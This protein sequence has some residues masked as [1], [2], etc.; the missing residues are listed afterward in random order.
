M[1]NY[2]FTEHYSPETISGIRGN[3]DAIKKSIAFI[4]TYLTA[5]PERKVLLF[6]G[7]AGVGKTSLAKIIA[8]S[9][10]VD[11]LIINCSADRS[12]PLIKEKLS[13]YIHSTSIEGSKTIIIL[14]E[15]DGQKKKS[16]FFSFI[17]SALRSKND[18]PIIA[19]CNNTW[20]LP[21]DFLK[22][23][24]EI[25][26]HRQSESTIRNILIDILKKEGLTLPIPI[27]E[28][29]IIKGDIRASIIALQ[30]YIM[31]GVFLPQIE[32]ERNK[33]SE[34]LSILSHKTQI[35]P[36]ERIEDLLLFVEENGY[37]KVSGMDRYN[38]YRTLEEVSIL[39]KQY[40]TEE[41]RTLLGNISLTYKVIQ[42][43]SLDYEKIN[44]HPLIIKLSLLKSL[45]KTSKSLSLKMCSD[46]S[47]SS[48][49]F[50]EDIFPI[51]QKQSISNLQVAQ[52]I[53]TK[54]NLE[55]DE[56]AL[57]LDTIPSDPRINKI[58]IPD[59]SLIPAS[60][61][62]QFQNNIV[63]KNSIDDLLA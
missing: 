52:E 57:L 13:P 45:N 20:K 31:S 14:D 49:K 23:C 56:I 17:E 24:V 21:K 37:H 2:Q 41:A 29:I 16:E 9:S 10:R 54:Y 44:T 50:M 47:I 26:F 5:T 12:F 4:K 51:L 62:P 34:T 11:S 8:K 15:I 7:P 36:S 61:K 59:K 40:R 53:T 1:N 39:L 6:S 38:F 3:G 43:E 46:F 42:K 27:L 30:I 18:N 32:H 48:S 35:S 22:K 25:K 55:K 33:Y 58:T 19:T 63:I 60:T 28:K